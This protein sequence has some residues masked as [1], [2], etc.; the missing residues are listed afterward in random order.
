MI[1]CG[2]CN[3]ETVVKLTSQD[4]VICPDCRQYTSWRLAKGQKSILIE[5]RVGES[6]STEEQP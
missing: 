6:E 5:G 4:R 2:W 3:S 1:R